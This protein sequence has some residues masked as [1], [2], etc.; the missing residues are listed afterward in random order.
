MARRRI[1]ASIIAT[2]LVVVVAAPPSSAS[3]WTGS[4]SEFTGATTVT[5]ASPS[6]ALDLKFT[7]PLSGY[8]ASIY[9]QSGHLVKLCTGSS[10][11]HCPAYLSVPLNTTNTY[12]GYV[13]LDSPSDGPPTH[14][15]R[16][17]ASI[18]VTNTG[19]TG[20]ISDFTG[21]TTVTAASPS[22]ALDLKFTEPL[23]GYRASIYDQSGHLVKLCTGS[24][25]IHCPAHLSVP[26]N[27]TNTYT[28]YVALDSPSD[29]PPTHDVRDS[30]SISVTNTGWTGAISDFT[31]S[32]NF[33]SPNESVTLDVA[34]TAPL[35]GY[36][37]SIYEEFGPLVQACS[38]SS[39]THCTASVSLADGELRVFRAYVALDTPATGTPTQDI[40]A[41]A[42]PLIVAALDPAT[43]LVAPP[44]LALQQ[45]L[46]AQ[47]VDGEACLLLGEAVRTNALPTSV[48]DATLVCNASGLPAALRFIAATAGTVGAAYAIAALWEATNRP[49][50]PAAAHPDC[51][52]VNSVGDCM[53]A[54][55][56]GTLTLVDVTEEPAPEPDPAG[57]G[58]PPLANCM[59]GGARSL[60]EDSMPEQYHH[61]AT[62]YGEW[63]AD[64]QALLD[65]YGFD[66]DVADPT[67]SWNVFHMPHRGPH[68]VEYHQW[69]Y[70][71]MELAAKTAGYGNTE[72]FLGLFDRWVVQ[73]VLD[74]PTIVRVAYWKCHRN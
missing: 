22:T 48:P 6:T 16:D 3:G 47:T 63:G 68:P 57:A 69:V 58:I 65:A 73:R 13:A 27:T 53:D 35:D 15:V 50:D 19:W 20:T 38:G 1:L 9:D 11:I 17:S 40:R 44:V 43:A 7:A 8:L 62:K 67:R 64:F 36:R 60:L 61:M 23:S 30:A 45:Q 37:V 39:N 32:S 41:V 52:Q 18:S 4:I 42:G 49:T 59:E 54:G 28:G 51:D 71:S 31:T 33:V 5:A 26:L 56:P 21:A 14:D 34:L 25:Y 2:V 46:L 55:N 29:G 12:T 72:E 66:L 74:D 24:S 70:E 10:Y